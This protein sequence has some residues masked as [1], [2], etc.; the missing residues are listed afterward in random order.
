MI[1]PTE[2]KISEHWKATGDITVGYQGSGLK[3]GIEKG[4]A[5]EY[6][7]QKAEMIAKGHIDPEGILWT[8]EEGDGL[9]RGLNDCTVWVGLEI[10]SKVTAHFRLRC[11]FENGYQ[12]IFRN[13]LPE[14]NLDID[15]DLDGS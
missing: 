1:C 2:H 4:V 8:L 13:T 14:Q 6:K 9:C 3:G 7:A 10:C 12:S 5:D 11:Y 15:F